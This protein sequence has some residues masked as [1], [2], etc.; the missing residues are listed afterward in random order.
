MGVPPNPFALNPK[1]VFSLYSVHIS[2]TQSLFTCIFRRNNKDKQRWNQYLCWYS[3]PA[4]PSVSN[5]LSA[6][7]PALYKNI[8]QFGHIIHVI[9]YVKPFWFFF[10]KYKQIFFMINLFD[11]PLAILNYSHLVPWILVTKSGLSFL[12]QWWA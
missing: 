1:L 10:F 2:M 4:L 9:H 6:F 8:K 3:F 11:F 5:L 12:Q 7:F